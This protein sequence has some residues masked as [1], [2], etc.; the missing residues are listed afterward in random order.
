MAVV[1]R[2]KRGFL[3]CQTK[4]SSTVFYCRRP[5]RTRL[6]VVSVVGFKA[7]AKR[8]RTTTQQ[9]AGSEMRPGDIKDSNH[10]AHRSG[11]W[12]CLW[13][14]ERDGALAHKKGSRGSARR[15]SAEREGRPEKGPGEG[16]R[17]AVGHIRAIYMRSHL[18][19]ATRALTM[20]SSLRRHSRAR[21]AVSTPAAR[22]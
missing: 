14:R 22:A 13:G 1:C 17:A 4:R 5:W 10:S 18:I 2:E 6:L 21:W 7:K 12:R 11:P 9:V 16:W 8:A 15:Q 3:D 19:P 20:R